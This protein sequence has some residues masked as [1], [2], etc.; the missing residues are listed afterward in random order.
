VSPHPSLA[1]LSHRPWPLPGAAWTWRQSW[2]D[3]LFAHWPI[4]AARLR[5]LVPEGLAIQEFDGVAW[6]AVVPFRMTG[7][8]RR[9]LPDLPWIS[10]FP[11]LNVRTYVERD[12]RPGVWF[13]SLDATNPLAVWAARRFFHLPYFRATMSLRSGA[14]EILYRSERAGA[15]FEAACQPVSEVYHAQAGSLEHWLTERYCLYA[16]DG[17]GAL[18][19]N[20]VHHPP[21]PLQKA[22]ARFKENTMA[23]SHGLELKGAPALLHFARRIDV[24][25]WSGERVT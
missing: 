24:V 1:H 5:P 23:E 18:W 25:V 16:R 20:D 11:E 10:A 9:Y 7:V 17:S 22:E 2:R 15:R 19:R 13:L 6:I 4:E 12:G 3:L 8:M 21:W 14:A